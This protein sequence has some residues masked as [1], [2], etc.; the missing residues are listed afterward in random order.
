MADKDKLVNLED[1]KVV[2]DAVTDLKS[3][4]ANSVSTEQISPTISVGGVS[5]TVGNAITLESGN[6]WRRTFF[7]VSEGDLYDVDVN[8]F[9][10]SEPIGYVFICD[11]AGIVLAVYTNK[12]VSISH[13]ETISIKIPAG[14]AM[15]YVRTFYNE[16]LAL[17]VINKVITAIQNIP[18][19]TDASI[20]YVDVSAQITTGQATAS[21]VGSAITINTN[22]AWRYITF[23]VEE[24]DVYSAEINTIS[25]G[26]RI[27][28]IFVCDAGGVVL[29][30]VQ[31]DLVN[32]SQQETHVFT[33]PQNGKRVYV[34]T[35][36]SA[37]LPSLPSAAKQ[38][39]AILWLG[40]YTLVK[41]VPVDVNAG[42]FGTYT[43]D[44]KFVY[45]TGANWNIAS[46]IPRAGASYIARVSTLNYNQAI[47]YVLLCDEHDTIVGVVNNTV[48][49]KATV[50]DLAFTAGDGVKKVYIRCNYA[51][52][53][54]L[55]VFETDANVENVVGSSL[56]VNTTIYV[57]CSDAPET[58]K[59]SADVV[60]TGTNDEL[61]LQSIINTLCHNGGG[62]IKLSRGTVFIGSFPNKETNL[63]DYV[64]LLIPQGTP[65]TVAIEG[66]V[67]GM[68]SGG[69][70][71]LITSDCYAGLDSAK[72]YTVIRGGHRTYPFNSNLSFRMHDVRIDLPWN[73]K[74]IRCIDCLYFNQ[75]FIERVTM[76]AFK[77]GY[78][79]GWNVDTRTPPAV[80]V[81]GCEGLRATGGSNYGILDD[82]RNVFA[83]GFH[84]GFRLSGEHLVGINLSAIFNVY[85]YTF[86]DYT[87]AGG[88]IHP[89]TL[90]NCCDERNVNLPLFV[91][92]G[93]TGHGAGNQAITFI[94]F[95]VERIAEYTPGGELG[96]YAVEQTPGIFRGEIQYTIQDE[97]GGHGNTV[98]IPFWANGSGR[99][100]KSRNQAQLQACD[101]VTRKS[102][103]ANYMQQ[104]YDT[105]L[106]KMLIFDGSKWVDMNGIEAT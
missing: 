59:S 43:V 84:K 20:K 13:V 57:A 44:Q 29:N 87:Y 65:C 55:A 14:A 32:K 90:I 11:T 103:A 64:A 77:N 18:K 66:D 10:Y 85:G 62:K 22:N 69:T 100:V 56:Q 94:D 99:G 89:I 78:G 38:G 76:S 92:N 70:A 28:Y 83:T 47:S 96:N 104:I 93:D 42:N 95:N 67:L 48:T 49:G 27:G 72:Q 34:S 17:P 88:S 58:Q 91:M 61:E 21:G 40:N 36:Y 86:G 71:F 31:N 50:E 98:S 51:V 9:N 2:G 82:Y 7:P 102:Y 41:A 30:V 53:N 80:A 6:A 33:V 105:T 15:V 63:D 12:S 4:F 97:Y 101:S 54:S 45:G 26:E 73:Q 19:L 81:V 1:L 3:A 5:G 106:N 68:A 35:Y 74:P 23:P 37:S 16:S 52:N 60:L 24:G 79:D 46:F 8:T 75:V 25:F 39:T